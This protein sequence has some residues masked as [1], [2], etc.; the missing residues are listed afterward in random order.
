VSLRLLY[1]IFIRVCGWLVL[2]GRSS[3]SLVT[4]KW[5]YPRR[6]GRPPVSAEIVALIERL[7]DGS[8][9]PGPGM[10][11]APDRL[12][13]AVVVVLCSCR[14]WLAENDVACF[15][16]GPGEAAP[17]TGPSADGPGRISA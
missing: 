10:N 17:G 15:P 5:T 6:A 3:A 2:L 1:L 9:D 16:S 8:A 11:R 12:Y 13:L 7:A 4:R 14:L